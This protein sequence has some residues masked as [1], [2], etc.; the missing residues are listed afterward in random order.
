MAGARVAPPKNLGAFENRL[1]KPQF[2]LN[3]SRI[4]SFGMVTGSLTIVR[5][6]RLFL[7]NQAT[8]FAP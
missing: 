4:F 8:G 5:D 2:S 3:K 7:R 1:A 6:R